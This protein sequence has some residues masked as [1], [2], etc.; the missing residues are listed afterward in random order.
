MKTQKFW[1]M[2][3][4]AILLGGVI[5]F[6]DGCAHSGIKGHVYLVRGNQMP[7]P[8]RPVSTPPGL[9]TELYIYELT[10]V[11]QVKKVGSTAFYSEVNTQLLTTV[12]TGTDGSFSVKLPPGT[13]SL[14]VKKDG[15]YYANM[16]DG[17]NNIYPVEVLNGKMTEVQFKADYDAVY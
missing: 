3:V 6:G 10:N 16:F 17:K 14:F 15:N 7:S 11:S 12:K 4:L 13:Y 2:P 8:D 9:E 1:A 5:S